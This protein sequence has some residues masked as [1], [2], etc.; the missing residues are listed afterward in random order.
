MNTGLSTARQQPSSLVYVLVRALPRPKPVAIWT[1]GAT[2]LL[3]ES[4][5][6]DL[7]YD[8]AHSTGGRA[9]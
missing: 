5:A 3:G 6:A 8:H 1:G 2:S 7:W 9:W 4:I